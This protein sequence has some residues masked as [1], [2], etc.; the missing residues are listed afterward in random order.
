MDDQPVA[1][2]VAIAALLH[3]YAR[4]VDAKDWELYR[5]AFT[6][7]ASIDYPGTI[8]GSRD[9]V[10]D[11]MA[12]QFSAGVSMSMHYITNIEIL[13][14]AGDTATVRA[15][16]YNPMQLAGMADLSY[17]GGYY[18]HELVR[19]ADGWKSRQLHEENVWFTNPPDARQAR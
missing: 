18:H 7:D 12:T 4:A 5:S 15:M 1:D 3:R 8:S 19:T 2:E 17:C 13:D 16:F 6:E 9:E 10:A 14:S 11:W